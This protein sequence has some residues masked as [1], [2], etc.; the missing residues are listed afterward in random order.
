MQIQAPPLSRPWAGVPQ[1]NQEVKEQDQGG[2]LMNGGVQTV[3]EWLLLFY[4]EPPMPQIPQP[5]S[6]RQSVCCPYVPLSFSLKRRLWG[7]TLSAADK[8][9]PACPVGKCALEK[10]HCGE[11][12]GQ[13]TSSGS[14]AHCV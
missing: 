10:G 12:W 13:C 9:K 5:L 2:A 4:L 1:T 7:I 14:K 8:T 6:Q 11:G 3:Q